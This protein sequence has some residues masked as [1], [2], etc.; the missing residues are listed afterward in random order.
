MKTH[1]VLTNRI[2]AIKLMHSIHLGSPEECIRFLNEAQF[3]EK[4]KHPHILP[5]IDVG[6]YEGFPY[7]VTEFASKGS[8]RDRLQSQ[9]DPKFADAY[10]NKAL[11]L[12]ELKRHSEALVVLEQALQ[13]LPNDLTLLHEKGHM[14]IKHKRYQEAI[15]ACEQALK[16]APDFTDAHISRGLASLFLDRYEAA[17]DAFEQALQLSPDSA[18]AWYYKSCS[19]EYLGRPEEAHQ[20]YDRARHF[21][22]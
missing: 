16:L 8:L 19:L 2:V 7:L 9:F 11:L 22:L 5:I 10:K 13:L 21:G 12:I 18:M 14:L 15:S 6:L 20:A 17:L 1:P 4:L 3:L